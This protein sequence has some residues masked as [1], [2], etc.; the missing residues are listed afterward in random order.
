MLRIRPDDDFFVE[1]GGFQ[2]LFLIGVH[3]VTKATFML[4]IDQMDYEMERLSLHN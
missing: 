2:G 1:R 4:E 3:G